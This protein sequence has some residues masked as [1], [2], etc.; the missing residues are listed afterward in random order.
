MDEQLSPEQLREAIWRRIVEEQGAT[1][2]D[3]TSAWHPEIDMAALAALRAIADMDTSREYGGL[4]FRN[5]DGQ[6][7]YSVP[8]PGTEDSFK[9][10]ARFNP[11][12]LEMAGIYH[13]HP[14]GLGRQQFFSASDVDTAKKLGLLSYI[15]AGD[16]VR[17]F[18]PKIHKTRRGM[19]TVSSKGH[20]P[21]GL[22][23]EGELVTTGLLSR[24]GE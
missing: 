3:P 11:E 21:R 16:Q 14:E 22:F 5:K 17:K 12:E 15:L 7:A 18:D 1:E 19:E 8:V 10:R 4:I 20:R 6:Y 24:N 9:L 13:N 2:L 23:A